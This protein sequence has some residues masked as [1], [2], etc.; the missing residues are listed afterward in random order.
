M[1]IEVKECFVQCYLAHWCETAG[2][3][4]PEGPHDGVCWHTGPD[5]KRNIYR[6]SVFLLVSGCFEVIALS[7]S[8]A[9]S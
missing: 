3:V 7:V 1:R 5:G 8:N 9:A 6:R 4:L 2:Q